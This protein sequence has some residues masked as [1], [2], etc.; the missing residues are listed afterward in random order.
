PVSST[1]TAARIPARRNAVS[2]RYAVASALPSGPTSAS[3]TRCG[4]GPGVVPA[5]V[6]RQT[7]CTL[8]TSG[9]RCTTRSSAS[10]TPSLA[11]SVPLN[12]CSPASV[13]SSTRKF[14]ANHSSA[15]EAVSTAASSACSADRTGMS[16]AIN[17]P[18]TS[19]A[20]SPVRARAESR[21]AWLNAVSSSRPASASST[22][23]SR[24]DSAAGSLPSTMPVLPPAN[25][26]RSRRSCHPPTSP[27]AVAL[28]TALCG[29]DRMLGVL[30]AD[31]HPL[32]ACQRGP[33]IV[34]Q[35]PIGR[36]HFDAGH[37]FTEDAHHP[38]QLAGQPWPPRQ[39]GDQYYP[40]GVVI[41]GR[42][43]VPPGLTN[44]ADLRPLPQRRTD[45]RRHR[46]H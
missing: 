29:T 46:V 16:P 33:V 40:L 9:S 10:A 36:Q 43:A 26:W 38:L 32:R 25:G 23:C 42:R 22:R 12:R 1:S 44:L 21:R 6:F 24:S 15:P 34:R 7:A 30:R 18:P 4:I 35:L 41:A 37:L 13:A 27:K 17:A 2:I 20:A 11:V 19:S 45:H 31:A 39:C 8:R 5:T 28:G 14:V 3:T